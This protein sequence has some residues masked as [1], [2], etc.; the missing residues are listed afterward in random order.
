MQ[1]Q[2]RAQVQLGGALP[3]GL[4]ARL[5]GRNATCFVEGGEDVD[6]RPQRKNVRRRATI[7]EVNATALP[8]GRGRSHLRARQALL[9]L[10]PGDLLQA[11]QDGDAVRAHLLG[12]SLG[13]M[14]AG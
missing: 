5:V 13:D 4:E 8:P 7:L 9:D 14:H 2:S 6:Y 1:L 10:A 12:P 3:D 11:P